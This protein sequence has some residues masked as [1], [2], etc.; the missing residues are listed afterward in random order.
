MVSSSQNKGTLLGRGVL[1]KNEQGQT[2]WEWGGGEGG[3]N[4]GILRERTI[5]FECPLTCNCF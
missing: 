1:L 4:S 5:L 2:R 3:Q